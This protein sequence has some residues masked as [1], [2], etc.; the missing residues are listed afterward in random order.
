[1]LRYFVEIN[2]RSQ[3]APDEESRHLEPVIA[4]FGSQL[5]PR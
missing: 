3:V 5:S 2:A 4:P 1:M